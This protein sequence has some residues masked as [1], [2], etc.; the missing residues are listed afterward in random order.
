MNLAVLSS[1]A[2]FAVAGT[3]LFATLLFLGPPNVCEPNGTDLGNFVH[4]T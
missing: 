3:L 2:A 4:C 1:T